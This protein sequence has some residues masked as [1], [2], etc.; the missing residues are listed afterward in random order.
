MLAKLTNLFKKPEQPSK[1]IPVKLTKEEIRE[2]ENRMAAIRKKNNRKAST[3][4]TIPY[5]EMFRDGIC[6]VHG[7]FYT[8]TIQFF[9]INYRLATFEEK[10][11]IFSKYCDLL[12]YFD[13]TIQF[14]LTFEN[15]RG[16]VEDLLEELEIPQQDDEFDGIRQEYSDMLKTQLVQGS[17]GRVLR[18]F[19]TFGIESENLK[20]ARM[21]LDGIAAE[22]INMLKAIGVKGTIMNGSQRLEAI[23]KSLSPFSDEPFIFDWGYRARSG[24][25]TKD[26]IAPPSMQ[27]KK[28]QFQ[29]SNAYG[30][31]HSINILAGELSDEVLDDYMSLDHLLCINMHIKPYDQVEALKFIKL[32]LTDV[33][34]MKIDEQKKAT[35]SGYDPDILPPS[36]KMYSAELEKMLEDLNSK[37]E[38]L[39]VV[40]LTI[41][42]YAESKKALKL[43]EDL[44]K[45][46]TQK[47]NCK[48]FPLEY[49]QEQGLGA[50]LPLGFNEIP[51]ERIL[52]TSAVAA[53]VPFTTQELFQGNDATYY[54]LNTLSNNMILANR[55]KLKNPNGL[56]LGTPGTG[57]SFSSK[58]EMTD[59]YLKTTDDIFVC[60]PEGEYR[61]LVENL[62]GQVI[63]I[64]TSSHHYINPMDIVWDEKQDEDAIAIKADF[65]ISLCELV[66]GG[67]YGLMPEERSVIDRCVRQIYNRFLNNNPTPEKMPILS[68]LLEEL[69]HS[70][71]HGERVAAS[72]EMYVSGSQNLFNHRTNV[73]LQNRLVCFD[74]KELGT[75]LRKI[76]MLIIQDQVWNRVSANRGSK[77]TWYYIDEFHLLL[78][79]EQTAKYSVEMWK[80][81]R[82]WGG[83]PTGLTQ[84]VKD[85]LQSQEIEN[86]FDNSDF[87]YMLSQAAGDR[88]I[89]AEKLHISEQQIKFV[90]NAGCGQGLI[91]FE[92][93][94]LPFKDAFPKDTLMYQ[95]MTT[96]PEDKI[97][98]GTNTSPA[99]L[100][101]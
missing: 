63:K 82:K 37:N 41:R 79:D 91:F 38:R 28:S 92:Y 94:I 84:N 13:N 59:V 72:L 86:I 44:L 46:I 55:K 88:D 29:I 73:N 53:W 101:S 10:N 12:N 18:K 80:R 14:Q 23:Y 34:Q 2:L 26:F 8:R 51:I 99:A 58:R 3:Q 61:P 6:W 39:Y 24:M 90:T 45:R 32:K 17:N 7:N 56:V 49:M 9:D 1:K 33:E 78:K 66:V 76:A 35:R 48:L 85:L 43:Q 60:D 21:K 100:S 96:D 89:L 81:F 22:I 83:I 71:E 74:I 77:S 62:H 19:I 54:G 68:D 25:S 30:S 75:Q 4:N 52:T 95:L 16:N 42:N 70:G 67:K 5:T 97:N 65:I 40:T 20:T 57:K 64:A 93:V 98:N 50:S 69:H 15:Q 36:I 87:I 27:F 31:I 47:N 11:S